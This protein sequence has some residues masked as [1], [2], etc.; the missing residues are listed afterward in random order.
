MAIFVVGKNVSG[1]EPTSV[2]FEHTAPKR[3]IEESYW[4]SLQLNTDR[5]KSQMRFERRLGCQRVTLTDFISGS[6]TKYQLFATKPSWK[7]WSRRI[8]REGLLV[9]F[10]RNKVHPLERLK[11]CFMMKFSRQMKGISVGWYVHIFQAYIP[12][13]AYLLWTEF[14]NYK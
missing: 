7:Y 3:L 6:G 8:W 5:I 2:Q 12:E 11:C 4:P 13:L 9:G 14:W 10:R 1:Q